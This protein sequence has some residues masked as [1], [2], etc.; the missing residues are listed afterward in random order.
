MRYAVP[1]VLLAAILAAFW[2]LGQDRPEA[3]SVAPVGIPELR[4]EPRF[5]LPEPAPE[6]EPE[7]LRLL[8]PEPLEPAA[9]ES[10]EMLPDMEPAAGDLPSAPQALPAL[11][12]SDPA[13]LASLRRL[14]GVES[15]ARWVRPEWII[16]RTVVVVHS[17]DAAAPPAEVRPLR[18]LRSAPQAQAD[19]DQALYWT[20]ATAQ[21]YAELVL[22]FETMTPGA[23][24]AQ[25]RRY[26]P[27]FQQA[28]E[29]LGEAEPWFND[30]LIDIIDHLLGAPRVE[31]PVALVPWE[32]RLRFAA[33]A[34]EA[35]SWGRKLLIRLGPE[36]SSLVREWL[37]AF[38]QEL[39]SPASNG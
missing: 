20:E 39:T 3:P 38:R 16:S 32:G 2:W 35:E 22:A 9:G 11:I 13:A 21:R 36:Q 25:Y 34:L 24:A 33:E 37:H 10:S 18:L 12:D 27:L 29:E 1:I 30:R 26:Y 19:S 8:A 7:V 14:I 6:A 31:L 23:A 17:L 5:P 28:W 15:V 4:P